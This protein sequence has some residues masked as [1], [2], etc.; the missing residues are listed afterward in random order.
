DEAMR[1][2]ELEQ[3]RKEVASLKS[4]AESTLRNAEQSVQSEIASAKSELDSAAAAAKV[5]VKPVDA[6]SLPAPAASSD[7]NPAAGSVNGSGGNGFNGAA[8]EHR[9][10]ETDQTAKSG[11]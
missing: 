4:E 9:V 8:V 10:V 5:E 1:E 7:G 6:G 3:L 2:T 11:T